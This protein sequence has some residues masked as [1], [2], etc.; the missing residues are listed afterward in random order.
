VRHAQAQVR[1]LAIFETKH[2][3][4]DRLPTARLLP[5]LSRMQRR[6]KEFLTAD[7]V[8]LFTQNLH[9]LQRNSLAQRQ[10]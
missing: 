2:D 6:Q 10:V 7:A 5:K 9:D 8:H 3:V 1:A 4:I